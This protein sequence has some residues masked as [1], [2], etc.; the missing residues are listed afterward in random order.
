MS[1]TTARPRQTTMAGVMVMLGATFV[2]LSVWDRVSRLRSLETRE[3]IE[4]FLADDGP[5]S[6]LEVSVESMTQTLHVVALVSAACAVAAVALGWQVLQRST[7]ARIALSVVAVPLFLTGLFAGAFASALVAAATA[8]L[9]LSPSREWFAGLPLPEQGGPR[10]PS[11]MQVWEQTSNQGSQGS[12]GRDDKPTPVLGP[13]ESSSAAGSTGWSVSA[14][15]SDARPGPVTVALVL[16]VVFASV[17]F[18]N[19]LVEM[20]LLAT[21]PEMALEA[22]REQPNPFVDDGQ[23]SDSLLTGA[24]YVSGAL[25]MIWSGLAITLAVLMARRRAW[26]A[27]A[28]MVCAGVCAAVCFVAGLASPL[29]LLPGIAAAATVS[30]LRRPDVRAWFD[31]G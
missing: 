18:L 6:G 26:A 24:T 11:R 2:V 19:A 10:Q 15:A 22:F 7:G 20:V 4:R 12:A 14:G 9:W 17:M 23:F 25:V 30:C 13:G 8:F 28:L 5:G 27:R 21:Q 16:T 29:I 31:A 3:G 1:T